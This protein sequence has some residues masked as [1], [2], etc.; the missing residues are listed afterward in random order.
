MGGLLVLFFL[1][2]GFASFYEQVG[3]ERVASNAPTTVNT[4]SDGVRAL[5]LLYQ[6]E[7]IRTEP[8]KAPWTELGSG[9]GL[10]VFVEP[11]DS[12]REI[13]STDIKILERWLRSGGT[14]LDLVSDPPVEQPLK[15]KDA[16]TGDCG[17]TAGP[18][19][20][21]GSTGISVPVN[22]ASDSA[23][24]SGVST[25]FV[26]SASGWYL[27]RMR[28]TPYSLVTRTALLLLRKRSVKGTSS[29]WRTAME[30]QMLG[31]QRATTPY[32]W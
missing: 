16:V 10:L 24:L 12:G 25:L 11:S 2:I 31:L 8:L 15:P 3:Q 5:F 1:L 27:P 14:L 4:Q 13:D 17:A 7:G 30:R 28:L 21:P 19:D 18:P 26:H 20:L 6:R 23:L 32:S 29:L 9:D 22:A